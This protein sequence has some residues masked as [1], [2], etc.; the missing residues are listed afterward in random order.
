MFTKFGGTVGH[1]TRKKQL[2]FGASRCV[3]VMVRVGVVVTVR[4]R[5]H[6]T[7]RHW[8]VGGGSS[9]TPRHWVYLLNSN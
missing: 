4:W 9:H 3:R 6:D 7:P 8:V 2:D 1:G 5:P